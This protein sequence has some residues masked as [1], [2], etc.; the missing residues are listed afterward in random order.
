M[1]TIQP[2]LLRDEG[3]F[4]VEFGRY[5]LKG[6]LGEGGM[7]RVFRAEL[8]G[9]DGFRKPAAVKIVRSAI[10]ASNENLRK[11]LINE[12][13]VGGLLH[14][15]NV[16]ETYDYGEVDGHPYIAM[17]FVRGIVLED[18]IRLAAPLEPAR[19]IDIAV[20]ICTGLDHAHNLQSTGLD[21]NLVHRD[22]KP[23]N[24]IISQDGLVKVMDFGIAKASALSATLTETG[25]T[26]G[27]PAYMSP[28]QVGGHK[29]DRR[30]D[31][32]S[33]GAIISELALGKRMF[34]GDS[35]MSILSAVIRVE[36]HLDDS[37]VLDQLDSYLPGLGGIV[38]RCL[39]MNPDLR[40]RAAT[41]LETALQELSGELPRL[42]PLKTWIRELME[43]SQRQAATK[44]ARSSWSSL[45]DQDGPYLEPTLQTDAPPKRTPS[46]A[47]AQST[48]PEEPP[49]VASADNPQQQ[50]EVGETRPQP[51]YVPLPATEALLESRDEVARTS[52]PA[53]TLSTR[54][55]R[56]RGLPTGLA[57]GLLAGLVI[58][59]AA[60]GATVL[61]ERLWQEEDDP[62]EELAEADPED[63][64]GEL[65]V[66]CQQ[67]ELANQSKGE[68]RIT[69]N[70]IYARHGRPFKSADLSK[71][72]N[73][74]SWYRANPE[75][76]DSLLTEADRDCITR[77]K[78]Q[79]ESTAK[80]RRTRRAER[81]RRSRDDRKTKQAEPTP[82][83]AK[84]ATRKQPDTAKSKPLKPSLVGNPTAGRLPPPVVRTEP[85]KPSSAV[86]AELDSFYVHRPRWAQ[87]S[88]S[89]D[90][91][92]SGSFF[93]KSNGVEQGEAYVTVS[94][95]NEPTRTLRMKR[96]GTR[97]GVETWRTE[98]ITF[99]SSASGTVEWQVNVKVRYS[100]G[101]TINREYEG[102]KFRL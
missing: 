78:Q 86:L 8:K 34:R 17:E 71:H 99:P 14:H 62:M 85:A 75:Y 26:K 42:P 50:V 82:T 95:P 70:T 52:L 93:L 45:D 9:A 83:E 55:E 32:F 87:S 25:T 91:E 79:E 6:I 10:A 73:G 69:R 65:T 38:H 3:D 39:R 64:S 44:P 66:P 68:L 97:G 31:L 77:V 59:L 98:K 36:E 33:L 81:T 5:T 11:A 49:S 54:A 84:Q 40:Y 12:A 92:Q 19:T 15:P 41:A 13:R 16:V 89:G 53:G 4:P 37:G 48:A 56:T 35:L 88:R 28:E 7:A 20:Q 76:S 46:A 18:L 61:F 27:T 29:L 21:T 60:V 90:Q 94:Y 58:A 47:I 63:S 57:L 22:L 96:S 100:N 1:Q 80:S 74:Q 67:E 30:S 2:D 101:D 102:K 24:I 72:F 23:S 51:G 43:S